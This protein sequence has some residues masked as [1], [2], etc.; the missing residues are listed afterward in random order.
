[1]TPSSA[2]ATLLALQP[3][4]IADLPASPQT[5]Y[6][7]MV[8]DATAPA[9]GSAVADSGAAVALVMYDGAAWAVI[10]VAAS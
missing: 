5:G 2:S 10:G 4:P 8:N 3:I 6:V 7:A 1:M 9:V